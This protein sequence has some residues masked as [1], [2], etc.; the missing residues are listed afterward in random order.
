M[1][2]AEYSFAVEMKMMDREDTRKG[3]EIS[4]QQR[5]DDIVETNREAAEE[6]LGFIGIKNRSQDPI[7]TRLSLEQKNLGKCLNTENEVV[8][9]D[10][11]RKVEQYIEGTKQESE[12]EKA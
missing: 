7:I 3:E 11:I 5:W 2:Q 10:Q 4:Q 12:G 9:R 6:V 8:K 1:T